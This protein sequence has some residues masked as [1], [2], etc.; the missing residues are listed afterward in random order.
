MD[1]GLIKIE[2]HQFVAG[3]YQSDNDLYL[4]SRLTTWGGVESAG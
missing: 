3:F 2:N 1:E 4:I